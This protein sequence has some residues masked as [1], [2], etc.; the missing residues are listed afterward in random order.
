MLDA[1]GDDQRVQVFGRLPEFLDAL[2][3]DMRLQRCEVSDGDG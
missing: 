1:R 2:G 3:P